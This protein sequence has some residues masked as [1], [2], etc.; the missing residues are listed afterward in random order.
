MTIKAKVFAL[1][2]ALGFA[3][4]ASAQPAI[5]VPD[6]AAQGAGSNASPS[7]EMPITLPTETEVVEPDKPR[8]DQADK[9]DRPDK[10]REAQ[11][12]TTVP[13]EAPIDPTTYVCGPGD[14]FE[15]HF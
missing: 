4:V 6:R 13:L 2:T 14:G 7:V 11:V 8:D 9:A 5:I 15:L 12:V 1:I 10:A 3:P